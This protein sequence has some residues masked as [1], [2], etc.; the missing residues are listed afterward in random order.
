[1]PY[2]ARARES[3]PTSCSQLCSAPLHPGLSDEGQRALDY[4][5]KLPPRVRRLADARDR[6]QAKKEPVTTKFSWIF[7]RPVDIIP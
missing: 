1:M 7:D 4:V 6:K 3:K 2:H 5:S